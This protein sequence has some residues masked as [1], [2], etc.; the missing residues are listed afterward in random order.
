MGRELGT[1]NGKQGQAGRGGQSLAAGA[2]PP[3]RPRRRARY[4]Q[5]LPPTLQTR[6]HPPE[7]PEAKA[8]ARP[9]SVPAGEVVVLGA[10]GT[11]RAPSPLPHLP[12]P[13][14]LL[15]LAAPSMSAP[16]SMLESALKAPSAADASSCSEAASEAASPASKPWRAVAAAAPAT[17]PCVRSSPWPACF[18]SRQRAAG[19]EGSRVRQV[20]WRSEL[21]APARGR[22]RR[23]RSRLPAGAT[24]APGALGRAL[25]RAGLGPHLR[26]A[27][28]RWPP[29]WHTLPP[30]QTS[31]LG[32]GQ[33]AAWPRTAAAWARPPPGA[34]G[35]RRRSGRARGRPL[36]ARR[37][38]PGP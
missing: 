8:R 35:R 11:G 4:R 1:R 22:R 5:A 7:R 26:R 34:A 20:S 2:Q 14:A 6:G 24:A 32:R 33:A 25:W 15:P 17:E 19:R 28:L 10:A 37:C 38:A 12:A 36:R 30:P 29:A 21:H 3:S 18:A 31:L 23:G 16:T 13:S 27:R 9:S